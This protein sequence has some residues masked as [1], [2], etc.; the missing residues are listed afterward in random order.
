MSICVFFMQLIKGNSLL[1]N[2]PALMN[3]M[4]TRNR[5][6]N[7]W[8]M[9]TIYNVIKLRLWHEFDNCSLFIFNFSIQS[10]VLFTF[11]NS[12]SKTCSPDE[13]QCKSGKC[14]L[15]KWKCD[16]DP[17]CPDGSDEDPET[18]SGMQLTLLII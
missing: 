5:L 17:D 2:L 7:L 3:M 8:L 11:L 4:N 9:S 16:D 15:A 1:L 6:T 10:L 14:I 13:F 12:E 18:C